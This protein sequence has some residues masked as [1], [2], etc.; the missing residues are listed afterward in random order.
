MDID[1]QHLATAVFPSGTQK[2]FTAVESERK[3]DEGST[4]TNKVEGRE[5]GKT[6]GRQECRRGQKRMRPDSGRPRR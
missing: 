5:E 2:K 3:T 6:K 1:D 4:A